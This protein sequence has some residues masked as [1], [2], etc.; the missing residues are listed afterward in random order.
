[1]A[2]ILT[3]RKGLQA[4][5]AK[6]PYKPGAISITTDER[7]IYLDTSTSSRIRLGDFVFVNRL[8]ELAADKY[9]PYSTVA[10]YYAAEE[11]KLYKYDG[12][13]FVA[14]CDIS[15]EL[16]ALE[17]SISANGTAIQTLQTN[18]SS[19]ESRVKTLEDNSS[20]VPSDVGDLVA[21][22]EREYKEA[23]QAI[24]NTI[25]GLETADTT[26][27]TAIAGVQSEVASLS[28]VVSANGAAITTG[29]ANTLKEAKEYADQKVSD[30]ATAR[31][32]AI[33]LETTARQNAINDLNTTIAG[34]QTTLQG[35]I[36][37]ATQEDA[38]I[39]AAF[40]KADSDLESKITSAYQEY[41]NT[42][43]QAA[44][45]MRFIGVINGDKPIEEQIQSPV[46]KGDTY[47][48]SVQK[49]Y[50]GETYYRGDLMIANT[51]ED[52]AGFGWSHVESGYE[53]DYDPKLVGNNDDKA[54]ILKNAMDNELG[55]IVFADNYDDSTGGT[56][57]NVATSADG[58]T[59][60][61]TAEVVWG[62][63]N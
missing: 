9:K 2:D 48:F 16:S 56:R 46:R 29:D 51:D 40:A 37:R 52:D 3:L 17:T 30:E 42:N 13:Q 10:L 62:S 54:I 50:L 21:R 24:L 1:M 43:M 15:G 23:D 59:T 18:H 34:L 19:L 33:G 61:V 45:A 35:E 7:A 36:N 49:T 44:D 20:G 5:L 22:I 26:L 58:F 14:I 8:S 39:R 41:V 31:D 4:D 32:T 28:T 6:A 12:T 27:Q 53:D 60:T 38:A 57:I 63:F 55:M 47:K 25:A 11:D